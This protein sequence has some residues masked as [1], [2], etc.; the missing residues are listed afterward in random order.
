MKLSSSRGKWIELKKKPRSDGL[1]RFSR[2]LALSFIDHY[3]YND[4]YEEEY[5]GILCEMSTCFENHALDEIGSSALFETVLGGLRDEFEDLQTETYNRVMSQIISF[6]RRIPA[7][8]ELNNCML[9]FGLFNPDEIVRRIQKI[10]AESGNYRKLPR[11]PKKIM[12]LSSGSMA[13]DV[14]IVSVVIQRLAGRFPSTEIVLIGDSRLSELFGNNPNVRI[15]PI[16]GSSGGSP[17]ERFKVWHGILGIAEKET[18]GKLDSVLLV[19]P[20]S[21]LSHLGIL[22]LVDDSKYLFFNIR[23]GQKFPPKLSLSRLANILMDKI[24][25]ES[26]SCHPKVWLADDVLSESADFAKRLRKKGCRRIISVGFGAG[27]NPRKRVGHDFEGKL[28]LELLR[29]PGTVVFLDRGLTPE[30]N[31][32]SGKLMKTL[33]RKKMIT[34]EL[35]FGA[36][37]GGELS[38]GVIGVRSSLGEISGLISESDEFI[39]YD[40]PLMHVAAALG[41]TAYAVFAGSNN[42]HFIRR[43]NACGPGRCALIHVDTLSCPPRFDTDD[44]VHRVIDAGA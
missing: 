2:Q 39:G 23:G 19:D 32:Y 26:E 33:A 37:K 13:A 8:K 6:C 41:V 15:V 20:D 5:I 12:V 21:S 22:P 16:P 24:L 35:V 31:E 44:I 36:F 17:V 1:R 42:P 40:S 25:S 28:I 10:R 30:E 14:A 38:H 43:W 27:D 4:R 3:L 11:N 29:K 34:K 7:G 9:E 18:S